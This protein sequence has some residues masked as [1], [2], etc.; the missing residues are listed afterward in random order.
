MTFYSESSGLTR[1]TQTANTRWL[2]LGSDDSKQDKQQN[3]LQ[4][5]NCQSRCCYNYLLFMHILPVTSRSGGCITAYS[6]PN[7]P[8]SLCDVTSPKHL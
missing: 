4:T 7:F 3:N 2:Q 1:D 5:Y 6:H 8:T